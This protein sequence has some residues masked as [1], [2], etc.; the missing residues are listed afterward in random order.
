MK[1]H[2]KNKRHSYSVGVL[3]GTVTKTR[4]GNAFIRTESGDDIYISKRNL[5]SAMSGD[6]VS[7]DLLPE[8]FWGKSPEGIVDSII[9]RGSTEITGIFRKQH[10][11]GF[12]EPLHRKHADS[13]II[14]SGNN[15]GA[16]DG[17]FVVCEILRYP[18]IKHDAEGIITEIISRADSE[19]GMI[20][21][22]IR[23]SGLD[24]YFTSECEHEAA[25]IASELITDVQIRERR[26]LRDRLIISIDGSDAKDLDDAVSIE[27]ND[28]GTYKLGVHI[29][30]VSEYIQQDSVLDKEALSRG[31]SVYLLNRVIPMLPK[32]ISNGICSLFEGADRLALTC[33]MTIDSEGNIT[34]HD[35]F[36]SVICNKARM[37]YDDVSDMIEAGAVNEELT[38]RYSDYNGYDVLSALKT[39]A[40]LASILNRKRMSLG[41]IDFDFD[42]S[43][44]ILDDNG[45]P[46]D[47]Y[48]AERRTANRMIEEFMLAA[49]KTVAEHF[50]N[51]GVPFIYRVHK[52]P[53][54]MKTAEL[55]AFL[56]GFGIRLKTSGDSVSPSEISRVLDEIQGE[57][58]EAVVSHVILRSMT[59]AYYDTEELGH[60]GLAFHYYTHF[61]SPIRRY[62]D[63]MI[64][65][66][67]KEILHHRYDIREEKK[68]RRI[69]EFAA[70]HSS[71]TER[72]AMDLERDVEKVKKA[73]YMKQHIGEIFDG[74]IS[75]VT[76]FGLFV[77]LP[78]TV[79]G[80]VSMDELY[81]DYYVYDAGNYCLTGRSTHRMYA[82]GDPVTIAVTG[83]D[84]VERQIDFSL[85]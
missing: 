67:I 23:S 33:E 41:S 39:M 12:V 8:M 71:E 21:A 52:K 75:G 47:V 5:S 10:T 69:T 36:E 68:L 61:T 3:T 81:D 57:P 60:F 76:E 2:R 64:H 82:L 27:K 37:V 46:V 66:I 44:I 38:Y 62:P 54:E 17:D 77:E 25:N 13:V 73:E 63:L 65:R 83:A 35:I 56:R 42:E 28:D 80:L 78:N 43:E 15:S 24:E 30:D 40:E 50:Y 14:R 32:S 55:S 34:G 45:L 18:S 79:E 31:N 74:V 4:S 29:A 20:K 7:V 72:R 1:K 58:Y 84:P 51:M 16:R 49:N 70:E 9:D 6:K 11:E 85:L 59:K 22:L 48:A 53:E 19:N 26:D